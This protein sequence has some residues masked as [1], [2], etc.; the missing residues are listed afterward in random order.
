MDWLKKKLHLS[1][2]KKINKCEYTSTFLRTS[3][4]AVRSNAFQIANYLQ[5]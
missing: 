4:N 1:I 3:A 2:N 5:V